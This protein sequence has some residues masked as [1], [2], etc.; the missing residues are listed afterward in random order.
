M[1]ILCVRIIQ[2]KKYDQNLYDLIDIYKNK[3][4]P[5]MPIRADFLMNRY[6]I[7]EGKGLGLKLKLIEK[8]W[9]NNN[10]KISDEQVNRI[11]KD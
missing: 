11:I 4:R 7:Q 1:D 6:K 3:I 2:L 9:V 10:F 5:N 8:E